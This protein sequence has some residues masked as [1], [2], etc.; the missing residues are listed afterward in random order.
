[1]PVSKSR[2]GKKRASK[3][4]VSRRIQTFGDCGEDTEFTYSVLKARVV[5]S[6]ACAQAKAT[7]GL[8]VVS[9]MGPS[10]EAVRLGF[11]D[12]PSTYDVDDEKRV[13]RGLIKLLGDGFR[14]ENLCGVFSWDQIRGTPEVVSHLKE[15]HAILREYVKRF[16][17]EAW[18]RALDLV[19]E[20]PDRAMQLFEIEGIGESSYS[21]PVAARDFIS[22]RYGMEHHYGQIARRTELLANELES[23]YP[24]LSVVT[25]DMAVAA[26]SAYFGGMRLMVAADLTYRIL[27]CSPLLAN[28]LSTST[29]GLSNYESSNLSGLEQQRPFIQEAAECPVW[30]RYG[31]LMRILARL[32]FD[33]WKSVIEG[34]ASAHLFAGQAVEQSISFETTLRNQEKNADR[35]SRLKT[36]RINE[37]ERLLAATRRQSVTALES[38]AERHPP[39]TVPETDRELLEVRRDLARTQQELCEKSAQLLDARS[40]L[41]S[42]LASED[43]P[44]SGLPPMIELDFRDLKGVVIG[45]HQGFISKLRKILPRCLFYSADQRKVDEMALRDRDFILFFTGYCNHSLADNALRVARTHSIPCGY[46]SHVN[47]TKCLADIAILSGRVFGS[48]DVDL[49]AA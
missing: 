19:T 42:L 15:K 29:N 8:F 31:H 48:S 18:E 4:T 44:E 34:S 46:T 27:A 3:S 47:V 14:K 24:D 9:E 6:P 16:A 23:R 38:V 20:S 37:L 39:Q 41:G 7:L 22:G 33:E 40:L 43:K 13:R 10:K 12:Q 21:I 28:I 17:D 36:A 26:A 32:K 45:G 2:R 35:E 49:V 11:S 25:E 5:D 1:M 30:G